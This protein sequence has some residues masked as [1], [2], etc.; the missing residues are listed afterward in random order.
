MSDDL[1]PTEVG[2]VGNY[3]GGLWIMQKDGKAYWAIE[4]HNGFYWDPCPRPV[5]DALLQ[6][7]QKPTEFDYD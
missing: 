6:E 4:N 1:E 3:Y 5:F 2:T 7:A